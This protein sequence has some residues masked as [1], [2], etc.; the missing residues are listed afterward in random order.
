MSGPLNTVGSWATLLID[1]LVTSGVHDIVI[2]PGSRS[3]PF[4]FAALHH[5]GLRCHRLVDERV[6]AFHALGMAR[7]TH[8]P[9]ALLCTSGTAPAHYLPAVIE[10]SLSYVP[11][12][13]LTADRPLALQDCGAPQTVDQVKMFGDHVRWFADLGHPEDT[14]EA[15]RGMR[16]AAAQAVWTSLGPTPGPVHLNARARKPLEPRPAP[17][18]DERAGAAC[19]ERVMAAPITRAPFAELRASDATCRELASL[20]AGARRGLVVCGPAPLSTVSERE[21]ILEFVRRA[22][23]PLLA[24]ATSQLRFAPDRAGIATLDAFDTVLRARWAVERIRPDL[25]LQLGPAP[26][27]GA[28]DRWLRTQ[29]TERVVIAPHGWQDPQGTASMLVRAPVAATLRSITAMLPRAG[30]QGAWQA[31]LSRLDRIA[32]RASDE[33]VSRET[34]LTEGAC[35]RTVVESMPPAGLLALGNSLPVRQVDTWCR[36][37]TCD[38]AVMGQRGANGIDGVIASAAGAAIAWRRPTALLVGDVSFA[39]DLAGLAAAKGVDVPLAVV[40]V[41]NAGGRI[42]EQLPIATLPGIEPDL[43]FWITP[44]EVDVAHA[45]SAYGHAYVRVSERGAMGE[46]MA[47]ALARSG[48]SVVEAVVPPSGALKQNRALWEAVEREGEA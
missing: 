41:N 7:V 15:L 32:W 19:A 40:V 11:L 28:W 48:C 33:V 20:I 12:V 6:A 10:A 25:I 9:V 38:L 44:P 42:F 24:E 30:A 39:H 3:T 21:A 35:F 45:A 2:T 22:G 18:D 16:R 29:P 36:G 27:S 34:S 43:P 4:V 14:E 5:A 46:A 8:L 13:L 17:S 26:T 31:A 1:A 37:G 47:H 23:F